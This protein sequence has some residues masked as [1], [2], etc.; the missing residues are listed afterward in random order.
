MF[1]TKD[2]ELAAYLHANDIKIIDVRKNEANKTLFVFD[3][4]D[5]GTQKLSLAF[6]NHD[7]LISASKLLWSFQ[8]IKSLLFDPNLERASK[9]RL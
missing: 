1:V 8:Q 2:I 7:D 4:G 6:Y 5:G 9:A 3:G